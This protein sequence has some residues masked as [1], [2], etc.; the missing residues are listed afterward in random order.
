MSSIFS[1]TGLLNAVKS[2]IGYNTDGLQFLSDLN[3]SWKTE[4][5]KR[6]KIIVNKQILFTTFLLFS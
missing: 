1:S 3:V 6:K 4:A 2:G 5:V